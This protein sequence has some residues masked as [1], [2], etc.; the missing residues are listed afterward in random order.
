ML[1][2]GRGDECLDT[3]LLF[4]VCYEWSAEYMIHATF[5]KAYS[6]VSSTSDATTTLHAELCT[7]QAWF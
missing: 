2:C 5:D 1:L 6:M 4:V 7:I 3:R